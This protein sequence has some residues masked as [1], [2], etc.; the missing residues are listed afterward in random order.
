M[1]F[2][3]SKATEAVK[4]GGTAKPLIDVAVAGFLFHLAAEESGLNA[5]YLTHSYAAQKVLHPK[6]SNDLLASVADIWHTAGLDTLR[7]ALNSTR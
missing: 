5:W 1:W 3:T 2:L 4:I 7:A 6:Q